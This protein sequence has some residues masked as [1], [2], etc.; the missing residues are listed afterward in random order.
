MEVKGG[1]MCVHQARECAM[2]TIDKLYCGDEH[3]KL[4]DDEMD[5]LRD[6]MQVL[7]YCKELE[8]TM[9]D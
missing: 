1:M 5:T 8:K 2:C 4:T 3:H 6:A 7:M 9:K